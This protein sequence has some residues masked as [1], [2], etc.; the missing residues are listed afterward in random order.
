[1]SCYI[2]LSSLY[3]IYLSREP[4]Q[5]IS[6]T[7]IKILPVIFFWN[8]IVM[9]MCKATFFLFIFLHCLSFYNDGGVVICKNTNENEDPGQPAVVWQQEWGWPTIC[10]MPQLPTSY[11]LV[12]FC[13]L[14]ILA[15]NHDLK[16]RSSQ[17]FTPSFLSSS[18]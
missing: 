18:N 9:E 15:F 8:E 6:E 14:L 3:I 13:Q 16:S 11:F 7:I 5:K 10:L 4:F 2:L 17:H 1:M 12:Y